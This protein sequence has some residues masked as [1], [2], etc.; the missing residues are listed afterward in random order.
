MELD[1][2][3]VLLKEIENIEKKP[4]INYETLDGKK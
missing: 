1:K 3:D 4:N 2:E